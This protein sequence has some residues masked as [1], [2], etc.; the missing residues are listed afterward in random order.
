MEQ[1]WEELCP[2]EALPLCFA[3]SAV[4]PASLPSSS[5]ILHP[6]ASAKMKNCLSWETHFILWFYSISRNARITWD[7]FVILSQSTQEWKWH[8]SPKCAGFS[9]FLSGPPPHHFFLFLICIFMENMK[10]WHLEWF[11]LLFRK[12]KKLKIHYSSPPTDMHTLTKMCALTHTPTPK[13]ETDSKI[14]REPGDGPVQT[15]LPVRHSSLE[16]H[17]RCLSS[18]SMV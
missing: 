12:R 3:P 9:G 17:Y 13:T 8:I 4:L 7:S 2:L 16:C 15:E 10:W 11:K 18:F 6:L 5:S 14:G 1:I